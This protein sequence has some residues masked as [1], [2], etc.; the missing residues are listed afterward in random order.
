MK[1]IIKK[2]VFLLLCVSFSHTLSFATGTSDSQ[3]TNN[4]N[5]LQNK[6][7]FKIRLVLDWTPNT[8]HIGAF[9]AKE[10]GFFKN[11]NLHVEII[12]FSESTTELLIGNNQAEF[13]FSY[14]EAFT[15]A[16]ASDTPLPI[17]AVAAVIQHNTSGF[18]S[19]KSKNI[20][21]PKDY[22]GKKYGA[23]GSP[24]E[25]AVISTLL[26]PYNSSADDVLFVQAGALDFFI[27]IEKEI[28]DFAWIFEGWT[29]IE[30][31]IRNKP[32][33]FQLLKDYHPAFDYYTPIIISSENFLATHPNI[34]RDFMQSL[35]EGYEWTIKNS[36]EAAT[37]L[38]KHEPSLDST[39]VKESLTYLAPRFQ[40]N[41][42]YWGKMEDTVWLQFTQWL[43]KNNFIAKDFVIEGSY[44]NTYIK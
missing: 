6:E 44:T 13:G 10:K 39:L 5:K 21:S 22:I 16:R 23:F 17:V 18:A 31:T 19:L 4:E 15:F 7:L 28:Y 41:A 42:E 26:H 2:V 40:D 34:A 33:D 38:I 12:P 27:A 11:R 8:N 3:T 9:V 32:L 36:T 14:Q 1:S 30:A 20:Q 24:I 43:Q 35:K 37:I 25:K 29:G